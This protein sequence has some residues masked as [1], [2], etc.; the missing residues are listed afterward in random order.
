M[1]IAEERLE[2]GAS[3][4]ENTHNMFNYEYQRRRVTQTSRLDIDCFDI[5]VMAILKHLIHIF[6]L[7][8]IV[9]FIYMTSIALSEEPNTLYDDYYVKNEFRPNK[10][11]S[12]FGVN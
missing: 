6:I 8:I 7:V 1:S 3:N 10:L 11:P 5:C 4:D 12:N 9:S 2:E